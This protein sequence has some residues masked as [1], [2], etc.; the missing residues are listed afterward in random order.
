[1]P[2][3]LLFFESEYTNS[4]SPTISEQLRKGGGLSASRRSLFTKPWFMASIPNANYLEYMT[5]NMAL[6]Q[7]GKWTPPEVGHGL[8]GS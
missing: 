2:S 8:A 5:W 3:D 7:D 4:P 1:M 6:L